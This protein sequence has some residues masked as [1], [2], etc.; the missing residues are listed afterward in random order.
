MKSKCQGDSIEEK[1][2]KWHK[3]KETKSFKALPPNIT[4]GF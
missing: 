2:R 4:W 1:L 3:D